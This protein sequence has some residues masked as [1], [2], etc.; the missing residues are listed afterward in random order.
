MN[1]EYFFILAI[2][3][4]GVILLC[5]GSLI[6]TNISIRE[7][8][9]DIWNNRYER[10]YFPGKESTKWLLLLFL[11]ICIIAFLLPLLFKDCDFILNQ[12]AQ[13]F[14][15]SA[16]VSIT[17]AYTIFGIEQLSDHE[18][19]FDARTLLV[20]TK[21]YPIFAL[22]ILFYI[23]YQL[24]L[25][26]LALPFLF[27]FVM[28]LLLLYGLMETIQIAIFP[29]KA[30]KF[31]NEY[32]RHLYMMSLN[33]QLDIRKRLAQLSNYVTNSQ[34]NIQ[35]AI[36]SPKEEDI[37]N[38]GDP[39]SDYL[40]EFS[41]IRF[42]EFLEAL[43]KVLKPLKYSLLK[44]DS[45]EVTTKS[46]ERNE[47]QDLDKPPSMIAL[48]IN[49][50]TGGFYQKPTSPVTLS[51]PDNPAKVK[52]ESRITQKLSNL[53]NKSF[54]TR[55]SLDKDGDGVSSSNLNK[56]FR[57]YFLAIR[58]E[59][60]VLLDKLNDE[61][62][63][64]FE[65]FWTFLKDEDIEYSTKSAREEF[66]I[67]AQGYSW[68]ELSEIL[69]K[70]R[71]A[72]DRGLLAK[73]KDV[74]TTVKSLPGQ[75]LYMSL[76][77][78]DLLTFVQ[79]SD[80]YFML[81][82]NNITQ[83]DIKEQEKITLIDDQILL[84]FRELLQYYI[85][86]PLHDKFSTLK[87]AL[88]YHEILVLLLTKYLALLRF[89]IEKDDYIGFKLILKQ[90]ISL[91]PNQQE[92]E[93]IQYEIQHSKSLPKTSTNKQKIQELIER[94]RL[95]TS[96]QFMM[97]EI[98]FGLASWLSKVK[99]IANADK[100]FKILLDSLPY[101][102]NRLF[103]VYFRVNSHDINERW[104]WEWWTVKHDNSF[105]T[106]ATF[107][108]MEAYYSEVLITK[109]LMIVSKDTTI[110]LKGISSQSELR[111]IDYISQSDRLNNYLA[112][113]S[114]N[115][116]TLSGK[117]LK[118]LIG[119]EYQKSKNRTKKLINKLSKGYAEKE[120]EEI[121]A[122]EV[123]K[124]VIDSFFKYFLGE[125]NSLV[126]D[127]HSI[128]GL[129]QY[130]KKYEERIST[131]K[132]KTPSRLGYHQIVKKE[133]FIE[134]KG[135]FIREIAERY[136]EGFIG[137]EGAEIIEKL[138]DEAQTITVDDIP[139]IVGKRYDEFLIICSVNT[140][141]YLSRKSTNLI[142]NYG[143]VTFEDPPHV[144]NFGSKKK[145]IPVFDVMARNRVILLIKI[146]DLG[147]LTQY[148]PLNKNDSED[149]LHGIFLAELKFYSQNTDLQDQAIKD[150]PDWLKNKKDKKAYLRAVG[151]LKIYEKITYDT[152]TNMEIYQID[153]EETY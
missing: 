92:T 128:K 134:E 109:A 152:T 106:E 22:L 29:K 124:N 39:L 140:S 119:K 8:F 84:S 70:M 123:P 57:S 110:S 151:A 129:L 121:G 69:E 61:I 65:T 95:L 34:Y 142:S 104:G 108:G 111:N 83:S 27:P 17:I 51:F 47:I 98:L 40:V 6:I 30:L 88:L 118:N 11:V 71:D 46:S 55:T 101:D 15:Y 14:A 18:G 31:I 144:L 59:D 141:H 28:Y 137:G 122:Y 113:Y 120:E 24:G 117:Y 41:E 73:A 53:V 62:I 102:L 38:I 127:T 133:D 132:I 135:Q 25:Y 100:Y 33:A 5:T 66:S 43:E 153:L 82:Y 131:K 67:F 97:D 91:P 114:K 116:K 130:Y 23:I 86:P 63:L 12:G 54:K 42:A 4:L 49:L 37:L 147:L 99:H 78:G 136:A 76:R 126:S 112:T 72:F 96:I 48:T 3:S 75:L 138:N 146:D 150:N 81:L 52:I 60:S 80:W 2:A 125:Y 19:A 139:K 16:L 148:S 7:I 56:V 89:S 50:R 20:A 105:K 26:P 115:N 145:S 32:K 77:K 103:G 21:I 9:N 45:K 1:H 107:M 13:N 36:F 10:F 79:I 64:Y 35:L 44:E 94:H 68:I 93:R 58:D 90:L 87:N 143:K 85:I 149:S 74:R